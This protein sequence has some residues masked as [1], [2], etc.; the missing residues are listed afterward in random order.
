MPA[1]LRIATRQ[2]PLAVWQ[3]EHVR[4]RLMAAHPGL[5]VI[6]VPMTTKGD[7]WLETPLS[8]VGGKGLFVKELERALF[9]GRADI[10]VHSMK[11]VEATLP[12]GLAL[13]AILDREDPT[14]ALVPQL[15]QTN[16]GI[17]DLPEG[18][19]IGTCSLR[20]RSQIL[21][22]RPDL[23][24]GML[25][26]N[27][28]S[29]L[30]K[31]DAGEHDAIVLASAGLQRL[32]LDARI[33]ARLPAD[34]CLPAIGQGIIGVEARSEDKETAALL[35]VLHHHETAHRLA[36]ERAVSRTLNGGCSAPIAGHATLADGRLELTAR[37]VQLNGD[38]T[39]HRVEAI[40][41]PSADRLA[42]NPASIEAADEL[43]QRV[44]QALLKSGAQAL[45]DDAAAQ[46]AEGA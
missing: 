27:V 28:N 26:G 15:G 3:A 20:R 11:D 30:A 37:V 45:L 23:K 43:G 40:N 5:D 46:V 36:A 33:G 29:R 34:V 6:L 18:A 41:L 12:D 14:D 10:A 8:R 24:I 38:T 13:L 1:S 31:L 44:A 42:D 25:R 2:S 9:D 32:A 22:K 16:T 7:Q 21:A 4:A 39:L 19:R 35:A 17:D